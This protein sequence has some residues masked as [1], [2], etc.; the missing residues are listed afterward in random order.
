MSTRINP[1]FYGAESSFVTITTDIA[2]K[3][4]YSIADLFSN[5]KY[6]GG[7]FDFTASPWGIGLSSI[8]SD[9]QA[10]ATKG[11]TWTI[12]SHVNERKNTPIWFYSSTFRLT[13]RDRPEEIT[14]SAST[15]WRF[16][17]M[18]YKNR[19]S[20]NVELSGNNLI[21]KLTID[22]N[23]Q[24]S[25]PET[26]TVTPVTFLDYSKTR[27]CLNNVYYKING[28]PYFGSTS[29]ENF[30]AGGVTTDAIFGFDY[31]IRD[32]YGNILNIYASIGG[33][34]LPIPGYYKTCYY[35]DD[36][37]SWVRPWRSIESVG[38]WSIPNLAWREFNS[39]TGCINT[40]DMETLTSSDC[41]TTNTGSNG[42][43]HSSETLQTFSNVSYHWEMGFTPKLSSNW[44]DIS[45]MQTGDTYVSGLFRSYAY[46]VID[47]VAADYESLT[48]AILHEI[49]FLGLPFCFSTSKA[50][51]AIGSDDIYLP[52]FD[53]HLITTG[54]YL[55][56]SDSLNL[57][58]AEWTD[59]FG[60]DMPE[61]D[62]EYEP[63][64]PA[65]GE[66]DRGDLSNE[67][68]HRY[69]N[70]G[71]LAQYVVDQSTLLQLAAFL[72][73]S[74]LPTAADLDADF[75]G[76]NP[77]DYIVSVQKYPFTLPN[78]GTSSDIYI[79]KN[80]TSLQGKKL[81]PDFGGLS[82]IAINSASTFD[83]GSISIPYYFNDFRD[84][85]SKIYLF[86]PFIGTDELDPRLYIGHALSL[87]YR[88][89][90]NTGSV[91][92]EIKRDGLTME[93]KCGTISITVPFLAANM[94]AYQNQLAQLSYSKDMT[95]IKGIGTALSAG[96]TMAA[97]ASGTL[98]SGQFPLA[99]ASNLTQAGVQLAANATQLSQLD[100]QIEH[101]APQLG[102]ISTA[103]AATAFFM[104]DRARIIIARPK[105]LAGYNPAQY[106]HTI[107]NACCKTGTLSAFSGFTQAATAI[108]DDVHTKHSSRQATEQ[109]RQL[110]RRALQ[111][112]IYL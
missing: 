29:F 71:G 95:K 46:M 33:G 85:Q 54:N 36:A 4:A 47:N 40:S 44:W 12:Y 88:V 13:G 26:T 48:H 100:Y 57:P 98:S 93:T 102:T 21:S 27:V 56:G 107:G 92:A 35:G 60:S 18:L 6:T 97:G 9:Y 79:G 64:P 111:N 15:N 37:A 83:F 22:D 96:F 86:M 7:S 32:I 74:Y 24:I 89:D 103:G 75:K 11:A 50:T 39:A 70:A 58:N 23:D 62:P 91:I 69:S 61:Y 72:N 31:S 73:G 20:P 53:E 90:Y 99:A 77:M 80:N 65:P 101:T 63:E 19:T 43:G 17:R 109:E 94:G 3:S 14:G 108:L 52:V 30:A 59:I 16:A 68:P 105:M 2:K 1:D 8:S 10:Q 67:Y 87:V 34:E 42:W 51:S 81:F 110:L 45:K 112:G 41:A 5:N 66:D 104:D 82:P 28:S 84:Y 78:V 38:Y 25:V 76:T 106:S 55:S 49:A